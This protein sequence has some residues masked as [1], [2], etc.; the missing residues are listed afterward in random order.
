M[1]GTS[2]YMAMLEL[3]A[4]SLDDNT[5][6]QAELLRNRMYKT[7]LPAV[8]RVSYN[9]E[10]VWQ[11]LLKWQE[12]AGHDALAKELPQLVPQQPV[13]LQKAPNISLWQLATV[14]STPG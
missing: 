11:S 10:T 4:T 8:T 9:G 3:R 2:P 6:S 5:P 7:T 13:W 1:D 14:I 12:Y